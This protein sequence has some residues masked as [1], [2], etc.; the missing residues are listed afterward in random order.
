VYVHCTRKR[1][2]KTQKK[3][4]K[5]DVQFN[6]KTKLPPPP[7]F[8]IFSTPFHPEL[9]PSTAGKEEEKKKKRKDYTETV[10]SFVVYCSTACRGNI[11]VCVPLIRDDI[12]WG[13]SVAPPWQFLIRQK[14]GEKVKREIN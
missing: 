3:R 12:H 5:F 1:G 10:S 13:F 6:M 7:I 8:V 9:L 14:E 4:E 11:L 2:V